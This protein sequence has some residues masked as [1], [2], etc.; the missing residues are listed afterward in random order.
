ME[1]AARVFKLKQTYFLLDQLKQI[2]CLLA[3]SLIFTVT[4]N[5]VQIIRIIIQNFENHNNDIVA[6]TRIITGTDPVPGP[7]GDT[8]TGVLTRRQDQRYTQAESDT[9]IVHQVI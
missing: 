5:K 6:H 9:I 8:G 7:D 2:G 4:S 3:Q 1:G